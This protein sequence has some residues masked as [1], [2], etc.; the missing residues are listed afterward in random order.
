[1]FLL[2]IDR[3]NLHKAAQR[4]SKYYKSK[5][6]K[7][8]IKINVK[9]IF[10]LQVIGLFIA[11]APTIIAND[12][13]SVKEILVRQEFDGRPDIYLAR[14]RDPDFQRKGIF[15]TE[16][17]QWKDQRRFTLRHLRDFGFGRRFPELEIDIREEISGLI[18]MIKTGPKYDCEKEIMKDGLVKCP[19]ILFACYGNA[20]LKVLCCE[21]LPRQENHLIYK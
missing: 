11:G 5:V 14:L 4:L 1:M 15:F 3:H 2:L 20:F 17:E 10:F 16:G 21:R 13:D 6:I 8:N 19:N 12:Y 7:S 9:I 18:E